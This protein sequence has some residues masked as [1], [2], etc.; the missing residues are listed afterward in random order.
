MP[1]FLTRSFSAKK[2]KDSL[3]HSNTPDTQVSSSTS[4][5][6]VLSPRVASRP[7]SSPTMANGDGGNT[8]FPSKIPAA[9]RAVSR[10]GENSPNTNKPPSPANGAMGETLVDRGGCSVSSAENSKASQLPVQI[11]GDAPQRVNS[12][13]NPRRGPLQTNQF[14]YPSKNSPHPQH[15][16]FQQLRRS[17]ASPSIPFR[18]P[19]RGP[20]HNG[21][22]PSIQNHNNL[23]SFNAL[24]DAE[25]FN[26]VDFYNNQS[27]NPSRNS[28]RNYHRSHSMTSEL[29]GNYPTETGGPFGD[30]GPPS[31]RNL[32]PHPQGF[33]E[34]RR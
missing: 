14:S 25:N 8:S 30:M 26:V 1:N 5:F 33:S 21:P 10:S 22:Y 9:P 31:S 7:A 29:D 17:T 24:H 16:H 6:R 12:P 4:N 23:A 11:R 34:Q 13:Y 28:N 32:K 19:S 20:S 15:D 27:R 3:K 2:K 18:A